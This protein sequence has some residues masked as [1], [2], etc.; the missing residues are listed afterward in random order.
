MFF[1]EAKE[2]TI[3]IGQHWLFEALFP[4]DSVRSYLLH[5]HTNN[6]CL[7]SNTDDLSCH[8]Q[9]TQAARQ[10]IRLLSRK[11]AK[12]TSKSQSYNGNSDSNMFH[13]TVC[14]RVY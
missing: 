9:Q 2:I 13:N 4:L 7:C 5:L 12:R 10:G 3:Y 6:G 11:A 14:F 8:C 1:V